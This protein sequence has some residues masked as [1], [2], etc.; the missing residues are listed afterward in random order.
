MNVIISNKYQVMLSQLKIDIIK[1]LNGEFE[2]DEVI[3]MFSNFYFN[4]MII[5][6]TAIKNYKDIVN[7]QR[8]SISLD[9][10]KVI[11]L[12]DDSAESSSP[13]YL[14]QL[15]SI[16]IYNFTR[17][18]EGIMY[19]YEHPNTYR[20]VAHI[21]Q[22]SVGIGTSNEEE[23]PPVGVASVQSKPKEVEVADSISTPQRRVIGFRNVTEHAGA[24]SLIYMLKRQLEKNYSV[25]AIEV[26]KN[27]FTY[28]NDKGMLSVESTNLQGQINNHANHE[29]V[30]LDLNSGEGE[31]FCTDVVYL[32]EPTTV[33]LNKLMLRDS[34]IFEKLKGKKVVLNMSLLDTNDV[35]EFEYESKAQIFFSIPPVDDK[36]AGS[37]PILDIFLTKLGLNRQKAEQKE[38]TEETKKNSFLGIFK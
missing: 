33:R 4:K 28:F 23:A 8:L 22:P 24:S 7:L 15:I 26:D 29:V 19:L 36:K 14:S 6:I 21:H 9:M 32:I 35:N 38:T 20:D 10:N 30:L 12:L 1:S 18:I 16:G 25:V 31:A 2:T 13:A 3:S 11:L 17:N 37:I 27:D 5:D 34:K